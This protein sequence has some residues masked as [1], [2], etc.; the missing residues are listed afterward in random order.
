MNRTKLFYT[1]K[2]MKLSHDVEQQEIVTKK[3]CMYLCVFT[4]G[5][6]LSN[7]R[8]SKPI[9][10]DTDEN[11]YCW[12]GCGGVT[13][14]EEGESASRMLSSGCRNGSHGKWSTQFH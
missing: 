2:W 4:Y 5:F 13:E 8:A 3:V 11:S 10:G 14:R 1:T 12:W 6:I 9:S 7:S